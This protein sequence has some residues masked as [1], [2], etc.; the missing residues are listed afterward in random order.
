MHTHE[1][2]TNATATEV[3]MKQLPELFDRGILTPNE[4]RALIGLPKIRKKHANQLYI[5][6]EYT[7]ILLAES[8]D[9]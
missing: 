5:R 9:S 3:Y 1:I 8:T 4:M 7:S 2:N 6:R